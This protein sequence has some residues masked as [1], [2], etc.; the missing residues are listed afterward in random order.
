MIDYLDIKDTVLTIDPIAGEITLEDFLNIIEDFLKDQEL[1]E[2]TIEKVLKKNPNNI[3][4][5]N[6]LLKLSSTSLVK[7]L[8]AYIKDEL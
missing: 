2:S 5:A 4:I 8:I 6:E 1:F 7:F 3:P